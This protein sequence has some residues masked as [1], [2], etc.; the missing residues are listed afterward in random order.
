MQE[1]ELKIGNTT[2][3]LSC[4]DPKKILDLAAALNDRVEKLK[5]ENNLSDVKALFINSIYL[6]DE[7]ESIN[8]ELQ[9]LKVNFYDKFENERE[10]LIKNYE[11]IIDKI[12]E[13]TEQLTN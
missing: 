10:K 1:I 8:Q 6:V 5:K 7:I 3:K 12:E 2:V 4:E 9:K 11:V 13:V